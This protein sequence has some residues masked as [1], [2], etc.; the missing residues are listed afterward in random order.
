MAGLKAAVPASA[1][2]LPARAEETVSTGL[3]FSWALMHMGDRSS[4][5]GRHTMNTAV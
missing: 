1:A 2:L 4:G 3:G 5:W